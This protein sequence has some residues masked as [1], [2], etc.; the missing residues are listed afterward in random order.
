MIK[1][2][3]AKYILVEDPQASEI[4]LYLRAFFFEQLPTAG[5]APLDAANQ[6]QGRLSGLRKGRAEREDSS[7]PPSHA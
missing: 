2:T 3:T 5:K 7:E 4:D 1:M 6:E